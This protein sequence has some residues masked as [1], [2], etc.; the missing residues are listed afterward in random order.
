[1]GGVILQI[2]LKD[3]YEIGMYFEGKKKGMSESD[4]ELSI[5]ILRII[6]DLK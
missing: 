2:K 5:N 1:M 3:D 4:I 6:Q